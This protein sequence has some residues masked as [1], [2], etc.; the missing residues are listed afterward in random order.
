V[1]ILNLRRVG[2]NEEPLV[3]VNDVDVKRGILLLQT[4]GVV[5]SF[6][7]VRESSSDLDTKLVILLRAFGTNNRKASENLTGNGRI[8]L[9]K[10]HYSF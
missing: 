8:I 3:H 7:A 2:W 5:R 4:L 9:F 1:N 10:R 6:I